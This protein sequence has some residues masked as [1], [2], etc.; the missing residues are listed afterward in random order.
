M[1]N[2]NAK[3]FDVSKY[4]DTCQKKLLKLI[5]QKAKGSVLNQKTQTSKNPGE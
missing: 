2:Q 5:E 3:N 4:G 1:V